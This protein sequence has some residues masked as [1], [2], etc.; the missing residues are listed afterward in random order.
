MEYDGKKLEMM[1][2]DRKLPECIH[3]GKPTYH[4]LKTWKC[5]L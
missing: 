2:S 5:L 1:D 4:T 3:S